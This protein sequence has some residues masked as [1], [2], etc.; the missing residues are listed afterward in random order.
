MD[1]WCG[2]GGK[3]FRARLYQIGRRQT[4]DSTWTGSCCLFRFHTINN[5][6]DSGQQQ[7]EGIKKNNKITN[8]NAHEFEMAKWHNMYIIFLVI[9]IIMYIF[10]LLLV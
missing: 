10:E 3:G 1:V 5:N 6:K 8:R 9:F 7:K 2:S 4:V